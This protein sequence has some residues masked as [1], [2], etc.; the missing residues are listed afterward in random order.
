MNRGPG[1]S[2]A[3]SAPEGLLLPAGSRVG[4]GGDVALVPLQ[5]RFRDGHQVPEELEGPRTWAHTEALEDDQHTRTPARVHA[6]QA[7]RSNAPDALLVFGSS[8]GLDLGELLGARGPCEENGTLGR[9]PTPQGH[10]PRAGAECDRD[11][12]VG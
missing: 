5:T 10:R 6:Q 8:L 12:P 9:I 1:G 7:S 3:G 2:E 11:V 4:R